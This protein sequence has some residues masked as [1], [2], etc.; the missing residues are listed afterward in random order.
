MKPN[1]LHKGPDREA[2]P[3]LYRGGKRGKKSG[4]RIMNPNKLP[5]KWGF[6]SVDATKDAT[7]VPKKS[8]LAENS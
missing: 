6:V 5:D 7:N 2:A 3:T 4:L 8:F 1:S